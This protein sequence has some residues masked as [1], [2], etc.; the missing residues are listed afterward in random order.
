[1]APPAIAIVRLERR[2]RRS[3]EPLRVPSWPSASQRAASDGG[4][5]HHSEQRLGKE[6]LRKRGAV[7]P[8]CRHGHGRG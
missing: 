5:G 2:H 4:Q 6:S 1:V 8:A 3:P 7:G